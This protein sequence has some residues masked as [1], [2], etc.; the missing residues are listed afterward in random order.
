MH[1]FKLCDEVQRMDPKI[2]SN[3]SQGCPF[4][5]LYMKRIH[6]SEPLTWAGVDFIKAKVGRKSISTLCQ[7]FEKLF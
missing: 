7:T 5:R 2:L 3:Y 1:P 6:K 4:T